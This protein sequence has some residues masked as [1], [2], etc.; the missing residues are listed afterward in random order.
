LGIPIIL[1][2]GA[3]HPTSL[4]SLFLLFMPANLDHTPNSSMVVF[5]IYG[6]P[7]LILASG[8]STAFLQLS[9]VELFN[10]KCLCSCTLDCTFFNPRL[11][12]YFLN[13]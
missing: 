5:A 1:V 6:M 2:A 9:N 7:L 4:P 11:K 8:S 10:H 12:E 13:D 3:F